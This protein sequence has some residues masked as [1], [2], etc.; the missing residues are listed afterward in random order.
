MNRH[1]IVI[2]PTESLSE[3]M[4]LMT[5]SHI[6]GLPVVDHK[7]RCV[8]LISASDILNYEQEQ[9]EVVAEANETMAQHFNAETQRWESVRVTSFALEEFGDVHVEEVMSRDLIAV[10]PDES[11]VETARVMLD[12]RVH[13]VLVLDDAQR[14]KG[15]VSA[16]DFVKLYA[17]EH[18]T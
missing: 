2:G 12:G 5:D 9:A 16:I 18:T 13:R 8:G 6:T 4:A 3:A 7:G 15:I 17:Q 14:L 11:V 1:L 10:R